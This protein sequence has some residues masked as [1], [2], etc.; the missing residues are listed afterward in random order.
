MR[1]NAQS[2]PIGLQTV[3]KFGM[4]PVRLAGLGIL[5]LPIGQLFYDQNVSS[6]LGLVKE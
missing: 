2:R 4:L 1:N 5:L 3:V 6:H